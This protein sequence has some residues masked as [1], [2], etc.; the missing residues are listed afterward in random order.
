MDKQAFPPSITGKSLEPGGS[1]LDHKYGPGDPYTL[2][3][4]EEYML[5][6]GETF[7]LVQHVDT[8]LA[9]RQTGVVISSTDCISSGL[10][11]GSSS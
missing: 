4:E 6:D 3:V 7:D 9:V 2:G 8:V 1:V 10:I 5:L 11:R